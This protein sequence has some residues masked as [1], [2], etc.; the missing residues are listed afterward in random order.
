MIR[1]MNWAIPAHPYAFMS[2]ARINLSCINLI[3]CTIMSSPVIVDRGIYWPS[4]VGLEGFKFMNIIA[5][6]LTDGL[7]KSIFWYR[8]IKIKP[9]WPAGS[10]FILYAC[11][12]GNSCHVNCNQWAISHNFSFTQ[13]TTKTKCS[14]VMESQLID[15]IN[16]DE[17]KPRKHPGVMKMRISEVP[18]AVINAM[19]VVMKGKCEVIDN[20]K[21]LITGQ[22]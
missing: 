18:A 17:I 13:Y 19:Q 3:W 8:P 22:C 12:L 6:L 10:T 2:C 15:R 21:F 11:M 14:A 9:G 4:V 7:L 20:F 5:L 16:A 1:L